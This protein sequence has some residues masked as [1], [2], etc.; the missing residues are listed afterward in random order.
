[1]SNEII[2]KLKCI[3]QMLKEQTTTP[4]TFDKASKYLGISKSHLYSLTSTRM[5]RHFKPGGKIVY[6]LKRIIN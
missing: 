3:E 1:M 6:F 5:I 2:E 4:L